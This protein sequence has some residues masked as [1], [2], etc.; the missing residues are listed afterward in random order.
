MRQTYVGTDSRR[1][2]KFR[3][4]IPEE[5]EHAVDP[6]ALGVLASRTEI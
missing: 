1:I 4:I 6:Y 3:P 5:R 2:V